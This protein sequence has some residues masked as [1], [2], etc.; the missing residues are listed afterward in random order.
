MEKKLSVMLVG[1]LFSSISLAGQGSGQGL[2][3]QS[4]IGGGGGLG[5]QNGSIGGSDGTPALTGDGIGGDGL[6]L[7][8]GGTDGGT[9]PALMGGSV[10]SSIE[11]LE[12]DLP[13]L[14]LEDIPVLEF[15]TGTP[16]LRN[17][18]EEEMETT[19]LVLAERRINADVT[20][21]DLLYGDCHNNSGRWAG[22]Y[23]PNISG[24]SYDNDL[25]MVPPGYKTPDGWD[26]DGFFIPADVSVRMVTSAVTFTERGPGAVKIR[27]NQ[28]LTLESLS[29]LER[30]VSALVLDWIGPE[31]TTNWFRRASKVSSKA[32]L[33]GRSN[34]Y[35]PRGPS[36]L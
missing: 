10:D 35:I 27:N 11:F 19:R 7:Q 15:S 9:P 20:E 8:S 6:G 2:G 12:A 5:L 21:R 23:G 30:Q 1:M 25:Y 26:C 33:N 29:S 16:L 22:V 32:A 14:N 24:R 17:M 28:W 13:A 18:T 4:T 31:N 36:K 3:L 34:Q